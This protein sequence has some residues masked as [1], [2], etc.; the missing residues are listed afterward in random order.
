MEENIPD[1]CILVTSAEA[2]TKYTQK[3]KNIDFLQNCVLVIQK[4]LSSTDHQVAFKDIKLADDEL[5]IR[6][7][8]EVSN[9]EV[10]G[11]AI[12][13]GVVIPKLDFPIKLIEHYILERE[14][15][16]ETLINKDFGVE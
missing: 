8:H 6:Y 5:I 2:L 15:K 7:A 4:P 16:V 12:I 14:K 9:N 11:P 1:T 10:E 13:M 3:G